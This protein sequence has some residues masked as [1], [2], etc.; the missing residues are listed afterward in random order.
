MWLFLLFVGIPIIE[1][2]LFIKVGGII[3]LW[4]TLLIVVITAVA[5]SVLMRRQG[6]QALARLQENL[7]TGKDPV[8]PIAHG[9]MIL[10][11][12]ILLL[13]PGFFT[14][15]LGIA[16]LIPPVREWLIRWGAGRIK[17][18]NVSFSSQQTTRTTN[19]STIEA[20]YEI[21]DEDD[22]APRGDSNWTRRN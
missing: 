17:V 12:G 21:L 9:A 2:A 5:G 10:V 1:I 13:T 8:T 11:S 3:G 6:L 4:P 7:R 16:L 22:D 19:D 15:S 18:Q 20:D 14:D